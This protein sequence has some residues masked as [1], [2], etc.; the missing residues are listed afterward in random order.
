MNSLKLILSKSRYFAPALVF[1]TINVFLGT[2][3]IYI[4]RIK[5]KLG[6]D[7]GELG[8]ALFCTALGTLTMVF[9]APLLIKKLGV[10]KA[11]AYGVFV[12]LFTLIIPF[13]IAMNT[14][15]TELEKEDGVTI[16]SAN[17]GFFSIGGFL[18]AGIGGFFLESV[19]VPLNHLLVVITIMMVL[20]I[21]FVK[22]YFNIIS[23]SD[24][25]EAFSRLERS[26]SRKSIY[27]GYFYDRIRVY[28]VFYNDGYR[29]F[30]W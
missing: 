3:A 16:M 25:K 5:D 22:H 9:L 30:S 14:L 28:S 18:G 19:V 17:H 7:E 13:N 2:W 6:I 26:V 21:I 20:N 23:V 10:G 15:V 29:T 1:A 27:G 12:L 11:T 8:V 24:E 4:P